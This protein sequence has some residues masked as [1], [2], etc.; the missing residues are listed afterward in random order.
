MLH[1]DKKKYTAAVI[2]VGRIGMKLEN[3]LKRLKPA[4][5]FGMW[6]AQ[7][8]VELVAVCDTTKDNLELARVLKSDIKLYESAEKLLVEIQPDIVSISTWK[9]T[10]YEI[11]KLCMNYKIPAIVCEKP[12]AEKTEHAREVVEE[13]KSKGIH[14]FINHRRRFDELLYPFREELFNGLVGEIRQVN[15]H[16]VFGLVTTGT[17][18]IDTLRFF[19]KE[20]AGEVEWV[21]GLENKFENYSPCDDPCVDFVL[22]FENG[23]K[24]F[25]QALNIKDYDIFDFYFY[26]NKGLAIFKNVGRDIEIHNVVDS[27]EHG[28][29]TELSFQPSVKRGGRPRDQFSFLAKN[30]VDTLKGNSESLSTGEDSLKALDILLAIQESVR[31][32]SKKVFI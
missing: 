22:G 12:I 30:V 10:H 32:N 15:A 28:G 11:M 13:A 29:F 14:L 8:D 21:L 2:G 5:H 9:D 1:V 31:D 18:L 27:P 20:I 24:V 16:Y 6:N 19:L 3:D 4:T 7:P 17:H 23:L 26:G 25:V